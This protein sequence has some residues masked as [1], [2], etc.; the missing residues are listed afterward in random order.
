MKW[1]A[2]KLLAGEKAVTFRP[3][4][5]S[6]EPLIKDGQEVTVVPVNFIRDCKTGM[7][8]LCKVRGRYM[9]HKVLVANPD[10]LLI[11]NNKGGINGWTNKVYG[12][13][14]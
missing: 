8:V 10:R 6:M 12:Y 7:V 1:V 9:L 13:V 2:D 11:G 5:K 3:R 14:K 4:G